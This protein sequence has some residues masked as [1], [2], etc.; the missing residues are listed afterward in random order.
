MKKSLLVFAVLTQSVSWAQAQSETVQKLLESKKVMESESLFKSIAFKNVGPTIMSGRVVDVDVNPE[1]SIEFY[2]AYASGGLWYTNNN[3]TSFVPVMDT[4]P[5]LNCGSVAVDWKTGVIWVGTGEINSSRSSYAGVG[6]LKSADKGKTW[7]HMGLSD[8]HHISKIILDPNNSNEVVVG[9]IGHLYTKNKERGVFKTTDGGKTWKQSL[10]VNEETGVIDIAVAPNNSNILY[11]TSWQ[12]DR[13]AHNFNGNGVG[14]GIYK[15]V[16]AGSSWQLISTSESGFP[17]DEFVGRIGVTAFNENIIYAVVDN[18]SKRP[19]PKKEES[20]DAKATQA[21]AEVVGAQIYKSI[22]S[23]KT[24]KKT[25]DSFIDGMYSSYGYYFGDITVDPKNEDRIY[26]TGVPLLFS[27][28]AGKSF[29]VI[30]DDNV[31]SDHHVVWIDPKNPNHII[32]GNDGGVN[33]SYDNGKHWVRCNSNAV[34]Q[35][36]AVNV[37]EQEPY[38]IYGGLQD[39]GVWVGPN[40]YENS[41]SWQRNGEYPYKELSGGD[42]MQVQ[43]DKRNPNIVFTGSQYGSYSRIDREKNTDKSITPKNKKGDEPF[44]FNWQTPILLSSHNQDILYFGSN[45]LHRSMNQ[46]DSWEAIS[47]DLTN[48]K[49]EGNVVYGSLTTISESPFQFGLLYTGSDDGLIQVS[50]DGGNSWNVV[51]GNLPQN[52][53]VSRVIASSHK[54]QRVYASLNGYRNDDFSSYVYVSDDYGVTWKNIAGNLPLSPVNV[55]K[56]DNVN[57]NILYVGSDNGLYISL[58]RGLTWQDFS[59]GMPDVAVHDLVI[60]K[61]SKDLIVGTH[62]RSLYKTSIAQVQQL[63]DKIRSKNLYL[64]DT[65]KIKKS[66][67]WGA[68]WDNWGKAFEPE[69]IFWFYSGFDGEVSFSIINEDKTV[70]SSKKITATKG[71]NKISHDLSMDRLVAEKW[72]AKNKDLK[73]KLAPNGKQYLPISKYIIEISQGQDKQIGSL[74]VVK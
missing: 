39:N 27:G 60:Q 6:L 74:E 61:K 7:E 54:K 56:E 40:D 35:F 41:T 22:D 65:D 19:S 63:D 24:W 28:D 48:G 8:S 66:D 71:L 30:D 36:Y 10:F 9:V 25:H 23:G 3:G 49:K 44:R 12:R 50:K 31:H 26:L 13:K 43:I 2:V 5:T 33:I 69:A 18:Q 15:S 52:L 1:N 14:S 37:D 67:R 38:N 70:V 64:F 29:E 45:F 58:D 16:D 57:E 17:N 62:G 68:K 21:Q 53:W 59:V 42:G 73:I 51:S 72:N 20:K 11:A 4:A 55:I 34:G 46:G 32:N 47:G